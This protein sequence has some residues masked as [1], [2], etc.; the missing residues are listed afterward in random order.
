MSGANAKVVLRQRAVATDFYL[1]GSGGA[2]T[3]A[4]NGS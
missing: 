3:A 1:H 4:G 2:N